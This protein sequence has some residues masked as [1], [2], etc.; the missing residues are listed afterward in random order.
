[1]FGQSKKTG[2][3]S[4]T[5]DRM[6][7]YVDRLTHNDK[8]R[9]QLATAINGQIA[10]RQ[11]SKKR[12]TGILGTAARFGSSPALRAQVLEAVS[13][14]HM[15]RGRM[16]KNHHHKARNSMLAVAGAGIVVAAIPRLRHSLADAMHRKGDDWG[17]DIRESGSDE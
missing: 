3:M 11:R 5:A 2:I 13:G 10:A 4:A 15:I 14:V 8:L 1:M 9:R 17:S 7:P 6:S 16:Q 12:K